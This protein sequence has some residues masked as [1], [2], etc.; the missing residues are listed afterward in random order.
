VQADAS[1]LSLPLAPAG[2]V[3]SAHAITLLQHLPVTE[4][5]NHFF[6]GLQSSIENFREVWI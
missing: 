4:V 1:L 3:H 2:G 6:S 5:V